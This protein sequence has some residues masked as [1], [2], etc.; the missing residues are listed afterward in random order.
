MQEK[1]QNGGW[2]IS[3]FGSRL[4]EKKLLSDG[5]V[6]SVEEQVA[7]FLYALAKNATTDTLTDY[8]QHSLQTINH[9]FKEVLNAIT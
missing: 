3:R 9:Y 8:F 5:Y 1:L 2:R 4:R 6:V 7:I